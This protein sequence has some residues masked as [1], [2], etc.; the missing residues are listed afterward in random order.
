MGPLDFCSQHQ[1]D[2]RPS[3]DMLEEEHRKV[4]EGE[5]VTFEFTHVDASGREIVCQTRL[6]RLPAAGR[7]LLRATVTDITEMKELQEKVR[8]SEKLA[9]VGM[10]AAGVAHEIGNPLMALSMAAQSL[11]RRACDQYTQSK[12]VLIREHIDRISRIVRQMGDLARPQS[13]ERAPCDV[14]ALVR[15]A[16][17][18]VRFDKRARSAEVR[19]ELSNTVPEVHAVE[20][21]L[22]Q[23]CI[24]LALNAFDA[25]T[26]LPEGARRC[27]TIRSQAQDGR[28][29]VSFRDTGPGV[30]REERERIF[31]PFFTTKEVGLGTGLG[32]SV[33]Y[34]ILQEHSGDLRLEEDGEPGAC[35]TFELPLAR[36]S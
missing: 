3:C 4:L 36:P 8:Q 31:Q 23:V 26:A 20:D 34:R 1:E 12:L 5:P 27:L 19:Y 11:E 15:R 9:A 10:L 13:G 30:T 16:V 28:L 22:T 21:Q 35:F 6:A 33:S 17:E 14:N 32:L 25:M 18:M 29:L 2:G 7:K 24:N